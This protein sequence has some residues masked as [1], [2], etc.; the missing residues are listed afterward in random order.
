[1]GLRTALEQLRLYTSIVTGDETFNDSLAD[2][3]MSSSM[4]NSSFDDTVNDT[5]PGE[6]SSIDTRDLL[7]TY[8]KLYNEKIQI[9]K[10][11]K[12]AVEVIESKDTELENKE[13]KLSVMLDDNLYLRTK[14]QK[15]KNEMKLMIMLLAKLWMKA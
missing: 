4:N 15:L 7:I 12:K 14:K 9:E 6:M 2:I 8:E 11:L 1:M 10:H 13:R 3:S 5:L